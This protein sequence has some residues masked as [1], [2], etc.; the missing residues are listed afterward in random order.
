MKTIW[1]YTL[2]VE[3]TVEIE[4]P[5]FSEVLC[6]QTRFE[7]PCVWFLVDTNNEKEVRLLSTI[8]TGNDAKDVSI[9]QYIGTYQLY[10]GNYVFHLFWH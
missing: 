5:K 7:E 10:G 4:I 3:N 2:K 9:Q 1:K 8:G 6:V